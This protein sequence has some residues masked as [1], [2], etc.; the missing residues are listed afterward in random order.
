MASFMHHRLL[1]SVYPFVGMKADV[2]TSYYIQNE[3]TKYLS[4]LVVRLFIFNDYNINYCEPLE[5]PSV[6]NNISDNKYNIGILRSII[7]GVD[8]GTMVKT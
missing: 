8:F 4:L 7:N 3:S 5:L 2:N 1:S 6:P